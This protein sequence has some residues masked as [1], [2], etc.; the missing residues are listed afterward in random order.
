MFEKNTNEYFNFANLLSFFL[1]E[2]AKHN[3]KLY[4]VCEY[5]TYQMTAHL[6]RISL[7]WFGVAY[8]LQLVRYGLKNCPQRHLTCSVINF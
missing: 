4:C 6:L 8:E 7:S 1:S 5:Y 3:V 2:L